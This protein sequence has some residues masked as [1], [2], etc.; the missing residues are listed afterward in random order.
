VIGRNASLVGSQV[1]LRWEGLR[2]LRQA[3]V[4]RCDWRNSR[5]LRAAGSSLNVHFWFDQ[6]SVKK[7]PKGLQMENSVLGFTY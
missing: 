3:D 6:G 1:K 4:K 5:T 2:S 7:D